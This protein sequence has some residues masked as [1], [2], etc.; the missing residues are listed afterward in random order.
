ML[1]AVILLAMAGP[2][3]AGADPQAEL[4]EARVRLDHLV[5]GI[6][7]AASRVDA[8]KLDLAGVFERLDGAERALEGA[9]QEME[10]VRDEIASLRGE[11]QDRQA[12]LDRRAAEAYR[13]RPTVTVGALLDSTSL[14]DFGYA[15][16]VL[17][18][19][20][21]SDRDHV[22]M[23]VDR[24]TELGRRE[25][26]LESMEAS[27]RATRDAL[28][29]A[30]AEL[31]SKLSEELGLARQMRE[32]RAEAATLIERLADGQERRAAAER[33]EVAP[34]ESSPPSSP[35]PSPSPSPPPPDIPPDPGPDAVQALIVDHFTPLGPD[36]V[37]VALCVAE[38][39]SGFD[40]HAENPVTG[41][42][43]VYQFMP[44]T[45]ES[46]SYAAGWGGSSVFDAEANVAVAAW[47]VTNYGWSNWGSVAAS[48]GA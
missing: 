18:A 1:V 42:A 17:D 47:T 7:E 28:D 26:Q 2:G 8:L 13:T 22:N 12:A 23:L 21:Q 36:Q 15:M 27:I 40:A 11:V 38:Q 25:E 14:A 30:V 44:S 33:V 6:E 31:Q 24:K 41:A 5:S 19:A 45:W 4:E 29:R 39:E 43:G 48:C 3:V 16:H 9:H 32:D 35:P 37:D 10:A 34:R 46:L 20:A